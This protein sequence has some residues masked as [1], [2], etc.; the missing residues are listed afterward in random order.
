MQKQPELIGLEAMTGHAIRFQGE[1][2]ILDLIFR[3]AAR[4]VNLLVEHLGAGVLQVRHDSAFAQHAEAALADHTLDL[5]GICHLHL[6][7][8]VL[9]ISPAARATALT[10]VDAAVDAG[11]PV[12]FDPNLRLNLWPDIDE[13]RV[14]PHKIEHLIKT[15]EKHIE[16]LAHKYYKSQDFLYLG[17]GVNYPIALEGALKLKELAYMHAEG[18]AAGVYDITAKK[19]VGYAKGVSGEWTLYVVGA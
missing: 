3:L 10:L 11:V 16:E 13:M 8:I 4:T 6:T 1:F 15:Q 19:W 14:I 9:G 12:S 2:V 7:G 5:S 18:F 17:R